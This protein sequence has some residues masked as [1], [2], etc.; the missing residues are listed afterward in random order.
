[1]VKN[2]YNLTLPPIKKLRIKKIVI[3]S[4]HGK[5]CMYNWRIG[6]EGSVLTRW[7]GFL[8]VIYTD[9]PSR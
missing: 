4:I 9:S 3:Y 1:M 6:Q 7:K 2:I 8:T 5:C